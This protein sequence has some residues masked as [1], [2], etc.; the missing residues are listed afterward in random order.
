MLAFMQYAQKAHAGLAFLT[1]G[2]VHC[3]I[4]VF[5]PFI[6]YIYLGKY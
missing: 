6:K 4:T 3:I 1:S 2:T 5:V